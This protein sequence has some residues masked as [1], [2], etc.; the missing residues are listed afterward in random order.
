MVSERSRLLVHRR[1]Y[2]EGLGRFVDQFAQIE[3]QLEFQLGM[4]AHVDIDLAREL[5]AGQQMDQ[6]IKRFKRVFA[7][8]HPSPEAAFNLQV[9]LE[10]L[11]KINDVRNTLLHS[12]TFFNMDQTPMTNN[13]LRT[14]TGESTKSFELPPESFKQLCADLMKIE[15]HIGEAVSGVVPTVRIGSGPSVRDKLIASE[16]Q[17]PFRGM[18][19][20]VAKPK[21]ERRRGVAKR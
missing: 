21:R 1:R 12:G 6:L 10:R 7:L 2:F 5:F 17:Y 15:A 13:R 19:N 8:R 3:V 16:W 11:D 9:A 4:V 14:R 20:K 18:P